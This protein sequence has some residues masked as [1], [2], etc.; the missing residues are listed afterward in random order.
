MVGDYC[1][2][3]NFDCCLDADMVDMADMADMAMVSIVC[4]MLVVMVVDTDMADI[5]ATDLAMA[6]VTGMAVVVMDTV[7]WCVPSASITYTMQSHAERFM[8]C[9]ILI[10]DVDTDMV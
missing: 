4:I 5:V 3:L 10:T 7:T 9:I 2:K 8:F 6:T 1:S